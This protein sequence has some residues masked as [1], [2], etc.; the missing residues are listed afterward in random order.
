MSLKWHYHISNNP[1]SIITNLTDDFLTSEEHVHRFGLKHGLATRPKESDVIASAESI[2]DQLQHNNV[3]ADSFTKQQKIKN[4]IKALACNFLDFDDRRLT[5][6][7]KHVNILKNICK[8]YAILKPGKGNGVVLIKFTDYQEG[9]IAIFA[10]PHKFKKLQNDPSLTQL[11]SIRSYIR[12][13]HK[14]NEIDDDTFQNIKPQP[15][16]PA[17]AHG[18]G[19]FRI[20]ITLVKRF[21]FLLLIR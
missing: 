14:H 9:M 11:F 1:N 21:E 19:G 16:G 7:S 18:S 6:D 4:S 2:W 17:Q 20:F 8:R 12:T 10:D 3:V 13:I 5:H 15:T